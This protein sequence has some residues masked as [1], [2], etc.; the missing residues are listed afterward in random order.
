MTLKIKLNRNRLYP[1]QPFKYLGIKIE[2]NLNWKD[3][4]TDIAVQLNRT[5]V[6]L[7]KIRNFECIFILKTIYF[8]IFDSH[9]KIQML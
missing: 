7:F 9:I 6:L 1:S 4:I 2:Q 5:N 8:A 3:H